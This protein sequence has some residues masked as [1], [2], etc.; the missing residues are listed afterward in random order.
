MSCQPG[1]AVL[2]SGLMLDIKVLTAAKWTTLRDIRLA[3]LDESPQAF[4]STH[5]REISWGEEQWIAEFDRG[6]WSIGFIDD[7][8]VSLLGATRTPKTP[9]HECY[10]EY[11]WVAPG[12][13]RSKVAYRMLAFTCDRLR[14]L[15][16]QTAFLYVLDGNDAAMRLYKRAGFT[17]AREPEPLEEYPG[18]SEE[19]LQRRLSPAAG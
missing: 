15:G 9:S 12:H 7:Q 5:K 19:L 14:A 1:D 17:S 3:A 11:L 6:D 18:R 16:V 10:L 13:R 4:L 2:K 8:A